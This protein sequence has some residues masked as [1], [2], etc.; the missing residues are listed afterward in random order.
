[1]GK[2]K[3][4]LNSGFFYQ[5]GVFLR[6]LRIGAFE[7]GFFFSNRGVL[8]EKRTKRENKE[9]KRRKSPNGEK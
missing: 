8:R 4:H 2:N 1:M 5:I 6:L 7:F 9:E 3:G